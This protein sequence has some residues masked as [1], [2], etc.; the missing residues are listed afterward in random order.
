LF[1]YL[2]LTKLN[3]VK[4]ITLVSLFALAATVSFSQNTNPGEIHGNFQ[5][6]A[7]YYNPDTLIGAP[8]VPEKMLMNG[9]GN[10]IYSRNNFT[11]G[12]RYESY[13]NTLQGFD[14]RYKGTGIPYRYATY[15]IENLEVTLGS[16]Y[17]QFGNGL[18]FRSYEERGLLYDNAMDGIRL[19]YKPHNGIYMKGFVAKQ[20]AFFGQGPGIVRGFDGEVNI[21]ELFAKLAEAK[22]VLTLGGS[23]VSKYQEDQDPVYVLPQNVGAW[24]GRFN[25]NYGKVS[26]NG[27]YAYK[28]ND[29]STGNNF[30]YKP[31]EAALIQASYSQKGLGFSFSAKRIDNMNFRSD[32]TAVGSALNINYLPAYNKL[33]TYNLATFYPYATQPNGEQGVQG[34]M[35]YTIKKG[36]LLGG[37][38]GTTIAV[39]YSN[40]VAINKDTAGVNPDYG[41][42]STYGEIGTKLNPDGKA[43]PDVY[44][45]DLN[46]E[47]T[48]KWSKS[49]KTIILYA[50]Q[51]Y[52]KDVIQG[53]AGYGTIYADIFVLD[54]TYKFNAKNALRTE[55]QSLTTKQD[56]G[57]WAS[58]LLEYTVSPHWFFSALDQYNYGNP[59][60]ASQLH[61][62]FGSIGYIQNA[63]RISI[64]YGR[65]R[66]GIFCVGGICRNVPASNG[67]T[68]TISSSF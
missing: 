24:A 1:L 22:A 48:H 38:Y 21:N 28:I 46:V 40:S 23:F 8:P 9:F 59:V 54:F 55:M 60:K 58:L 20:R 39:N 56:N 10:I 68:L 15:A 41:Y 64:N 29:P 4:R 7:Q 26:V 13:L 47:I 51:V 19:K 3:K 33:H 12:V 50:N 27:E 57:N 16:F 61:Y 63:T 14:A 11:A 37:E 2:V 45:Q 25:L 62:Y 42:K 17:D 30:I 34:D 49:F 5:I 44:F 52:N 32:R 6:D 31:G 36:S 66:S 18:I 43:V 65:Q 53:L 35:V 67:I